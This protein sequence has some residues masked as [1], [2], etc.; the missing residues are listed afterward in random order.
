[1]MA[2]IDRNKTAALAVKLLRHVG[3]RVREIRGNSASFHTVCTDLSSREW[4]PV[5]WPGVVY[6]SAASD[7]IYEALSNVKPSMICRFGTI[8]LATI[9]SATTPLTLKNAVKL[10]SGDE[11]VRDIGMHDGLLRVLCK[12]AGFF[13][14][15]LSQGRKFVDLMLDDMRQIDILGTWCKQ[16]K[17]FASELVSAQRVRFRDME[18][19]MHE[20]PW[21]RALAGR[22]VL[23][24]HPF[25]ELIEAQYRTKRSILFSNPLMLPEFELKTIKAVQSI[26]YTKTKFR[27]WFEAL[28]HM[29]DQIG[30]TDFDIA[31]IGCGAYGMPLAAHAKRIGKK[32]VHLGG[33]TQLLFG[34]KGKRWETGHDEIKRLFNDYWVYPDERDRP[35]NYKSVEGGA[36][37]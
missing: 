9:A 17:H 4:N 12:H 35:Q 10:M 30:N 8:E 7:L 14:P 5:Q 26:A 19:Y 32:A 13:P 27:N 22:K 11:V 3:R 23:V 28:D 15:E 34:I 33:Q 2:D 16:E 25:A 31:I 24:I 37:W 20:K 29:K 21:T 6:G 18:P 36:Y 1:M